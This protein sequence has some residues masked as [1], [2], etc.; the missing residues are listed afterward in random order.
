MSKSLLDRR[1]DKR[2]KYDIVATITGVTLPDN[3]I[4]MCVEIDGETD[5]DRAANIL[6]MA[7]NMLRQPKD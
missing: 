2:P 7:A 6:Q 3:G 4:H 5:L 1:H